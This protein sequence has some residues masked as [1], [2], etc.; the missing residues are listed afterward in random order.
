VLVTRKIVSFILIQSS[1]SIPVI[2]T[3]RTSL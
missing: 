3:A 1:P 2:I